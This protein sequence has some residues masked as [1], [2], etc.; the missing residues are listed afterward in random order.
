[1]ANRFPFRLEML[2]SGLIMSGSVSPLAPKSFVSMPP[3]RGVAHGDGFRRHQVQE[4]YRRADDGLRQ[5]GDCCGRF[6]PL[7]VP[8]GAGRFLPGQ[9]PP[10]QRPRRRRQFWQC[11]CFHWPEGPPGHRADGE[12][13]CRCRRLRRKRG[14][15]GLDRRYRRAARCHQI[16]RRSGS[17]AG[18]SDRRFLVRGRQGDHDDR[19]LSEGFHP[20]RR[21]RRRG[22]DD[23]R[24]R[25][26]RRHDR[27]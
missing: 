5:T 25:Q 2:I 24:H 20:Q 7:E 18:R 6:Y 1:M 15:P 11:Q 22:R 10:W 4:P 14:L 9:S 23:Q 21:D 26:G 19:H 13:G 16:R 17:D 27:A 8:V 12:V 3:L